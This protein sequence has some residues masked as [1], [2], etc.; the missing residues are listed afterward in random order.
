MG[1]T[2]YVRS[3]FTKYFLIDIINAD[4]HVTDLTWQGHKLLDTII[5]QP[6]W[7]KIKSTALEKGLELTFDV[8]KVLGAKVVALILGNMG[9]L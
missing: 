7:E 2:V 6:V 9:S 8:V 5:S 4:V 1:C 3:D